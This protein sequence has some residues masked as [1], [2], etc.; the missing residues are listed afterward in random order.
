MASSAAFG[1][2]CSGNGGVAPGLLSSPAAAA[3]QVSPPPAAELASSPIITATFLL[4]QLAAAQGR[5]ALLFDTAAK[6]RAENI[7]LMKQIEGLKAQ[8]RSLQADHNAARILRKRTLDLM[9]EA[10]ARFEGK[11]RLKIAR[12]SSPSPRVAKEIVTELLDHALLSCR[13]AANNVALAKMLK[14]VYE[15]LAVALVCKLAKH[16]KRSVRAAKAAVLLRLKERLSKAKMNNGF[17]G[18]SAWSIMRGHTAMA[19]FLESSVP[20]DRAGQIAML[21]SFVNKSL[22]P[23]TVI[24]ALDKKFVLAVEDNYI[25]NLNKQL[26]E[27]GPLIRNK[28]FLSKEK[29]DLLGHLMFDYLDSDTQMW[30][31]KQVHIVPLCL[32]LLHSIQCAHS[33]LRLAAPSACTW[34]TPRRLWREST[35]SQ[36]S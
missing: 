17:T 35:R 33:L 19:Q 9:D 28:L 29:I 23:E 15:E 22:D 2:V 6:E 20:G 30:R 34:R 24:K 16:E 11:G 36:N 13:G 3:G 32:L 8:V 12:R 25:S 14:S 21:F 31:P 10:A 4:H 18:E 26:A 1:F 7:T 27:A 5:N